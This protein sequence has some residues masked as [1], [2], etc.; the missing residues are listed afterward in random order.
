MIL[1]KHESKWVDADNTQ[2]FSNVYI[3]NKII[4]LLNNNRYVLAIIYPSSEK[5]I[6]GQT[7]FEKELEIFV[8]VIN[9][10]KLCFEDSGTIF[11]W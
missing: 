8:N 5:F 9:G 7:Y 6:C 10:T 4:N 3:K 1:Y 11:L 2:N